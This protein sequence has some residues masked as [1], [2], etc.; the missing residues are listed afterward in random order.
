MKR[1]LAAILA[2][3]VV[4]FSRL[5]ESDEEGT[6][7]TLGTYREE[8]DRI[9]SAHHGRIFGSAGD[10]VIAEFASPVEAVRCAVDIQG[11]LAVRNAELPHE[12]RMR[13]RIGVN[14]GDVMAEDDNLFGDG[15]NIATRLETL[16]QPDTIFVSGSVFD[17]IKNKVDEDFENLGIQT[18]KNIVEPVRVYRVLTGDAQTNL[19][20]S[21]QVASHAQRPLR[22]V[23]AALVIATA[24]AM[25][26]WYAGLLTEPPSM[27]SGPTPSTAVATSTASPSIAVL[28]FENK[29]ETGDQT[30]FADGMTDDLITELAKVDGLV[31][32]ARDSSFSFRQ[33]PPSLSEIG[34]IL[35]VSYILQG[36]VRRS[37]NRVRINATLVDAATGNLVWGDRYDGDLANVFDLQESITKN[38]VASLPLRTNKSADAVSKQKKSVDP[39][40]YEAFLKGRDQ[41]LRFSKEDTLESRAH[42]KQAIEIDPDFANA[43]AIL[44]WNFA[45]EYING[46]SSSP[47]KTLA[48]AFEYAE[49][50]ISINPRLPFSH[51]VKGLVHRERYQFNKAVTEAR[52]AIDVDPNYANAHVL[53]ATVLYY[54]GKAEEGLDMINRAERINPIYPSNYPYHKGQALFIL[55][56]YEE[57]IQA[58][59]RGLQQNPTSQRLR[60]WL[61]ATYAHIGKQEEAEWEADQILLEDPD[62]KVGTISHVFPFKD[63]SD[64]ERFKTALSKVGFESRW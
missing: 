29:S 28:P 40:A 10:S 26:V 6:L 36:S 41:F 63:Q 14:L 48:D 24:V 59:A 18:V 55:G 46:W 16:A 58:F 53:L 45:F 64:L 3:D 60:V 11:A 43:Y 61:A 62:F 7:A 21:N 35:N 2:A 20:K 33:N 12:R 9:I 44:G 57:A 34:R 42:L 5:M 27:V 19:T 56:R 37:L 32:I 54:T 31:V 23:A 17:Q 50:A 1:R 47:E 4:G 30:F 52:K 8:I 38:I 15:V 51:F 25:S 22:F 39:R 49:K 13:M